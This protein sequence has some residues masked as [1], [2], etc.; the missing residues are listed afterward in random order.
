MDD[1]TSGVDVRAPIE[2]RSFCVSEE[3]GFV[4]TDPLTDLPEYYCAW[5][6]L[7]TNLTHLVQTHQLR[8]RVTEMPLL[9]AHYLKGHR[10]LRLAHLA[11]GIIA[12]GYVWQEGQDRP[13]KVLPKALAVPYCAVSKMLDLP[14][15]LV[16][17]DCVLA[18]WRL[19][20]SDGPME[21]ENMDTLFTVPG[22]DSG[23]GFFLVSLLVEQAACLGLQGVA[24]VMNSMLA[25]DV[26]GIQE[27]LAVIEDSI[28]RMREV[29]KLMHKYVDPMLF[30]NTVRIFFMGW[31]DNP[32][33][34]DGMWYEGAREEPLHLFG[35]SASQSSSIQCFDQLL[36]VQYSDKN[37]FF[38]RSMRAYM[39]PR[40]RQL[41]DTLSSRPQ[42][43]PY[44][45][46]SASPKLRCA[47]NSCVSALVDLRCF[48]LNTVVRY[49]TVPGSRARGASCPF[50]GAKAVMDMQGTSSTKALPFLK[51]MRDDTKLA[52]IMGQ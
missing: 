29:F 21:I 20:N 14:P 51:S 38:M 11:L 13:A 19:R 6:D 35:A 4:L 34:P 31:R 41:I 10:E 48:H 27:A 42:L 16:Y 47:Y 46:S 44:V 25:H 7:A 49:I 23:K 15:I 22:G 26:V 45:L 36:G 5:M 28:R 39:P 30:H 52:L 50:S 40:H 24:T 12:M 1:R 2:L 37:G 32:S 17:A 8:G 18:N 33:L 43:R 3:N 9:S